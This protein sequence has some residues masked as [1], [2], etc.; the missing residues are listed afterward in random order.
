MIALA[1]LFLLDQTLGFPVA[2]GCRGS[3]TSAR[4]VQT[5]VSEGSVSTRLMAAEA[6]LRAFRGRPVLGWG[7]ENFER[8]FQRYGEPESYEH[9]AISFDNAHNKIVDELATKGI[10]GTV[11]Y[12]AIW[13][14]AGWSVIRLR[15]PAGE[16]A[17]AYAV[18][19]ALAAY[20]VQ[21]LFLFDTPAMM[22]QWSLLLAW[23]VGH[24]GQIKADKQAGRIGGVMKLVDAATS[25]FGS[26]S[27]RSCWAFQARTAMTAVVAILLGL[28]LYL[29]NYR[30]LQ[31]ASIFGD[32]HLN[33]HT[34][35]ERVILAEASFDT[36]P[37]LANLPR[38]LLF[39][40]LIEEW[41]SYSHE[42]RGLA[43][44]ITTREVDR[45]LTADPSDPQLLGR[46]LVLLQTMEQSP[47]H[48]E[49]LEPM[50]ENLVKLAPGRVLT[51]Q[52]LANQSL[53]KGDYAAAMRTIEEF[54]AR[55]PWTERYFRTLKQ[56]AQEGLSTAERD[57]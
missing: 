8:I 40:Q 48:I 35:S 19:G 16:E 53:V 36:F 9:G 21:N 31:A 17:L 34:L 56:S 15:R 57:G 28:S 3:V 55:A 45:A 14:A 13:I 46:A 50:L 49:Q 51:I 7:P 18:L 11:F 29:L 10:I 20:F 25:R 5:T 44:A 37:Y 41:D 22:L 38:R 52:V 27:I 30:P 6:G 54:E 39:E 42:E 1:A 2:P 47:Q 33:P 43:L 4:L 26:L 24:E 23:A 32:A 12:L